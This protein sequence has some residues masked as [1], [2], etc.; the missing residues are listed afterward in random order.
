MTEDMMPDQLNELKRCPFCD[1]E[2]RL[3]AVICKHCRQWMPGYTYESAIRDLIISKQVTEREISTV[4]ED[5]QTRH[6]QLKLALVWGQSDKTISL[7]GFDLSA[8]KMTGVN[9]S[10]ADLSGADLKEADLSKANLQ[11]ANLTRA[12]L[13]RTNLRGANLKNAK[14]TEAYM[15]EVVLEHAN[16]SGSS[17]LRAN[18]RAAFMD[19]AV[20]YRVDMEKTNMRMV[21]LRFANLRESYLKETQLNS[22]KLEEAEF[23]GA[24][25]IRTDFTNSDL[26]SYQYKEARQIESITLPN[27]QTYQP[28]AE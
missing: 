11:G 7:R 8:Q 6:G 18:L 4:E 22:A 12:N 2:I 13:F 3:K 23:D 21:D 24:L 26:A 17:L 5:V 16:L 1:E 10:G 25:L 15:R 20:L 27:G 19:H 28:P 14:F 9:L